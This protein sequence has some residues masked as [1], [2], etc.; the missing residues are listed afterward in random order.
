MNYF[1]G[2][3]NEYFTSELQ[4][5]RFQNRKPNNINDEIKLF[6]CFI[7]DRKWSI[8]EVNNDDKESDFF[9]LKPN[10]TNSNDIFF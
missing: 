3:K 8:K 10:I 1:F 5:P 7:N 2:I 6:K 4:I 9:I